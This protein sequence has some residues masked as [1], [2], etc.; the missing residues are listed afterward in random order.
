MKQFILR[1]KKMLIILLIFILISGSIFFILYNKIKELEIKL[2]QTSNVEEKQNENTVSKNVNNDIN[3]N[4]I[5]NTVTNEVT[6]KKDKT[7]SAVSTNKATNNENK[8]TIASS[9]EKQPKPVVKEENNSI[10]NNNTNSENNSSSNVNNT[11]NNTGIT[12]E[13][14]ECSHE[15]VFVVGTAANCTREGVDTYACKLC[16]ESYNEIIPI[17]PNNH[18]PKN[19]ESLYCEGCNEKVYTCTKH[20]YVIEQLEYCKLKYTCSICGDFYT[21]F[22]GRMHNGHYF[23]FVEPIGDCLSEEYRVQIKCTICEGGIGMWVPP[24]DRYLTLLGF[25]K[26]DESNICTICNKTM[27]EYDGHVYSSYGMRNCILCGEEF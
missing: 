9:P 2:E 24:E 26:P 4:I 20:K 7:N 16:G 25:H 23:K 15:Y 5:E 3:Q 8:K 21:K 11:A 14:K 27:Q 12:E 19:A 17:D 10:V 22:G 18:F 13:K 1:N 6:S